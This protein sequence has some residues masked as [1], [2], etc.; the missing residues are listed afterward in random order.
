MKSGD[1]ALR[2]DDGFELQATVFEPDRPNGIALQINSAAETPRQY[3]RA[4]SEHWANRGFL[5][6][7]Y[8]YRDA[9][10]RDHREL[11][12]SAASVLAWGKDFLRDLVFLSQSSL[13]WPNVFDSNPLPNGANG[14]LWTIP[15]EFRCY[16]AVAVLGILCLFKRRVLILFAMA[17]AWVIY[18]LVLI[19]NQEPMDSNWRFYCYFLAGVTVWLYRDRMRLSAAVSVGCLIVLLASAPFPPLFSAVLPFAGGYLLLWAGLRPWPRFL[20]WTERTDL[21]YGVYLYA[22]PVQ[23]LVAMNP[24]LRTSAINLLISVPVTAAIAWLSWHLVEKRFLSLKSAQ[25][26]DFDPAVR[27]SRIDGE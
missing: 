3:Y 9:F 5:V 21:S 10:L 23:Q 16:V 7:C 26:L 15:I 6:V 11:I 1:V 19:A 17:G 27:S 25:F 24:R 4:V 12:H 18:V 2:T 13:N 14:S 22:F 20:Q 8:D